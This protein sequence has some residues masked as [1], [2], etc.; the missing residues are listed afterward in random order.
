MNEVVIMTLSERKE[1]IDTLAI[2]Y[3][4]EKENSRVWGREQSSGYYI[5]LGKLQGACMAFRLDFT[6]TEKCLVVTT[7]SE[8]NIVT[9]ID[10]EPRIYKEGE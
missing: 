8:R 10:F 1:L 2:I 7:R 4:S 6:E 3:I 5:A 9:K